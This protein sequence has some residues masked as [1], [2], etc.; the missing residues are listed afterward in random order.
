MLDSRSTHEEKLL[1]LKYRKAERTGVI[2]ELAFLEPL[3]P[4]Q[5]DEAS[6]K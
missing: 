1:A 5:S 3:Q 4:N 6:M 2:F